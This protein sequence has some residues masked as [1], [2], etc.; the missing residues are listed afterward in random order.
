MLTVTP[1]NECRGSRTYHD[2]RHQQ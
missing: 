1:F 2:V